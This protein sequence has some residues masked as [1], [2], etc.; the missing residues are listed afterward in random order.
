[1]ALPTLILTLFSFSLPVHGLSDGLSEL[2][3]ADAQTREL[4][5][6]RL[7]AELQPAESSALIEL[8][9]SADYELE[10]RITR[11]LA[12]RDERLPLVLELFTQ[13]SRRSRSIARAAFAELLSRWNPSYAAEPISG[14]ALRNML[15][16][17][18]QGLLEIPASK[19]EP[20][21][22]FERFAEKARLGPPL[23]F[24]RGVALIP[25]A[26]LNVL[27]GAPLDLLEELCAR[28]GL[29]YELHG[30]APDSARV[31]AQGEWIR[32]AAAR[33]VALSKSEEVLLTWA[34]SV[35][36]GTSDAPAAARALASTGWS[37]PLLW[38]EEL[39]RESEDLNALSGLLVAASRGRAALVL[40]ELETQVAI[41][42]RLDS[43]ASAAQAE[44][45]S[46]L[47]EEIA[48]GLARV[49]GRSAKGEELS[50][51][52]QVH[53]DQTQ[54][55]AYW[56]RLLI[57]EGHGRGACELTES[58]LRERGRSDPELWYRALKARASD[59][60]DAGA[61]AWTEL[62]LSLDGLHGNASKR[63][64]GR[65]VHQ[66]GL[67]SEAL[68]AQ[69]GHELLCVELALREG[70]ACGELLHSA[71]A[72]GFDEPELESSLV[73]WTVEF[74][75]E[76]VISA[77]GD[78]LQSKESGWQR[79]LELSAL[80]PSSAVGE[81]A[82]DLERLALSAADAEVQALLLEELM[83]ISS[84]QEAHAKE[85]PK[86]WRRAAWAMQEAAQ[87][88]ALRSFWVKTA[89]ATVEREVLGA[90]LRDF[91]P[92]PRGIFEPLDVG[93]LRQ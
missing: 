41:R 17:S 77:L 3:S 8:A 1:M 16:H 73:A 75:R 92:H 44:E 5:T 53:T 90:V 40:S 72:A 47:I 35:M 58:I 46:L 93:L 22:L 59:Q 25:N 65:L 86:V 6:R 39:W 21:A 80:V 66:L 20:A 79:L 71:W 78:K 27:R 84:A 43:L 85:L 34:L 81:A 36:K 87:E 50:E 30:H 67:S 38:F 7:C 31:G 28:Y 33:D 64:L 24:D 18:Q 26:S 63:D 19:G 45:S 76:R 4:A 56:A 70:A 12:A 89:S 10:R 48:R 88:E 42:E 69:K 54:A 49:A 37:A 11:I 32:V 9:K 29:S 15:T 62:E 91:P 57:L 61:S 2:T 52:W 74:G 14:E 55:L 83:T 13:S 23:V 68:S 82:D 60:G 51:L